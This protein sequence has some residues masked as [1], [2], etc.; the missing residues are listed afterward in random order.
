MAFVAIGATGEA[1]VWFAPPIQGGVLTGAVPPTGVTFDGARLLLPAAI[2]AVA[3][4]FQ[5]GILD[6]AD[7]M[8]AGGADAAGALFGGALIQGA[9]LVGA[10]MVEALACEAN[11]GLPPDDDGAGQ[12]PPLAPLAA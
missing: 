8:L 9:T 4:E 11:A 6:G 1:A 7:A 2:E 10:D 5:A 3:L 12:V